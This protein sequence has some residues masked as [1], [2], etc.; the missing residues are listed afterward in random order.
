MLPDVLRW[1]VDRLFGRDGVLGRWAWRRIE[2]TLSVPA[3]DDDVIA[4]I[5]D[6]SDELAELRA[7]L[8]S[9]STTARVVVT[10]ER[11]VVAEARRTLSY[12]ALY[13]YA[14]DAVLVNRVP[15]PELDT[16]PVLRPWVDAQRTQLTAIDAAF[17]P[18]PRLSARLRLGEPVGLDVLRHLG[19]ELYGDHDPLARLATT[20]PMEI[21]AHGPSTSV[22]IFIPGIQRDEIA[23]EHVDGELI[24]T[25][26]EHRRAIGLP[27]AL[28]GHEVVRAG[29]DGTHLEVVLEEAMTHVG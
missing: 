10:P 22:R 14:V 2:R 3:P 5:T 23:L 17:S 19:R 16:V 27:D 24:V 29:L 4:S 7:V 18:L 28:L 11:V 26:G 21:V 13:G 20:P 6:I 15:G 9:A 25:L 8:E 12:L 1:Y